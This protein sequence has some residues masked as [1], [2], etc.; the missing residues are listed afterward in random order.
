M[1]GRVRGHR[2]GPLRRDHGVAAAGAVPKKKNRPEHSAPA[3]EV[4]E[5]EATES[6]RIV[7]LESL[8]RMKRTSFRDKDRTHLRDSL[9]VGL[10]DADWIE[11]FPSE[12][13]ARLQHLVDTPEG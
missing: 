9:E 7:A 4:S 3:P 1:V 13:A 5:S 8:V 2:C 12:L 6:F 10:I 11:R